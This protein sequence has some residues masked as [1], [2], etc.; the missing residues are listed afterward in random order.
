M[1]RPASVDLMIHG[2]VGTGT[3]FKDSSP[4]RLALTNTNGVSH[5]A[6]TC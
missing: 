6:D 5:S 1:R 2:N 4:R 3:T